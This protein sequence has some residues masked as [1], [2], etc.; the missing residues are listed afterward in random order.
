MH[1]LVNKRILI[2][3]GLIYL[4]IYLF[5]YFD[6]AFCGSDCM[7]SNVLMYRESSIVKDVERSSLGLFN[8]PCHLCRE[9]VVSHANSQSG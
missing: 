1:Q 7:A 6:V 4:F 5:I 3:L 8:L 9:A 2:L